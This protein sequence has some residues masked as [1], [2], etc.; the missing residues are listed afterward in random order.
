MF[1]FRYKYCDHLEYL[2]KMADAMEVKISNNS[3]EIPAKIGS[4][5]IRVIEIME[6]LQVMINECEI[7]LQA[8]FYRE[9]AQL[10]AFT[11]RFDQVKNINSLSLQIGDD[12]SIEEVPL[13]SGIVLSNSIADLAYKVN[14]GIED[15]CINIFFTKEWFKEFIGIA[16]TE[17]FFE[18][19]LSLKTS[20]LYFE[21]LNFDYREIM[22]NIFEL[23]PEHP[24]YKVML[25]N[26]ILLL[27]ER[28]LKNIYSKLE[29]TKKTTLINEKTI[30]QLMKVEAILAN[31]PLKIAP[32]ITSLA[33]QIFMSETKLKSSFKKLY[34][35][36]IYNYYQKNRMLYAK[37]LLHSKENSVKSVGLLLGFKNLSNF[38]IAYK[39]EFGVL[40]SE[41]K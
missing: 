26:R 38:T 9:A 37:R 13:S 32:T 28:F 2:Q 5:Y 20:V 16:N 35:Y 34:G 8:S 31:N 1:N 10:E 4:G 33:R 15:R 36:S 12:K 29:Y 6:G 27:L 24:M 23:K 17:H 3:L 19:Y 7:F 40:P 21:V 22:E 41:I 11:L 39:K 14:A 30:K 18:K 25:R